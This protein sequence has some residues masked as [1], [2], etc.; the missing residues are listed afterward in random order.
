MIKAY[1]LLKLFHCEFAY[2]DSQ[3]GF[4]VPDNTYRLENS[5]SHFVLPLYTPLYLLFA[6]LYQ[7]ISVHI[8]HY[9][10]ARVRVVK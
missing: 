10:V 9:V 2:D 7:Q 4:C 3:Q 8:F 1:V 5:V 6:A